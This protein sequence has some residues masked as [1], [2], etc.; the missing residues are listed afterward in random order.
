VLTA[1]ERT[2]RARIAAN[3]RWAH[4]DRTEAS[5]RQRRVL[6]RRFEDAVDPD[7]T[8]APAERAARAQNALAQHMA[9]LSLKASRARKKAS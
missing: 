5:E 6:L 3:A 9:A 7:R 1:S 2:L 8:L 4:E